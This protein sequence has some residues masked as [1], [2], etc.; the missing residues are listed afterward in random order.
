MSPLEHIQYRLDDAA[1]KAEGAGDE[2]HAAQ[3]AEKVRNQLREGLRRH[4]VQTGHLKEVS[5]YRSHQKPPFSMRTIQFVTTLSS[6]I[7][8]NPSVTE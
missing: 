4:H 6:S 5:D 2:G 3:D 8:S 1:Q 7:S